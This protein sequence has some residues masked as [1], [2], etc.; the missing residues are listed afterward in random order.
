M[1][2]SYCEYCGKEYGPESCTKKY[3]K[4]TPKG[5]L[6]SALCS[7]D[8]LRTMTQI[9]P[10]IRV[11]A[12]ND[13]FTATQYKDMKRDTCS[14]CGAAVGGYHHSSCDNEI[15]PRCGCQFLSCD[16]GYNY[17]IELLDDW[18]DPELLPFDPDIV[19]S[20]DFDKPD[21]I[22]VSKGDASWNWVK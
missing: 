12:Y 22:L 11:G 1:S 2:V 21:V 19:S 9:L 18:K 3:I 14:D 6:K 10:R 17:D 5:E 13:F 16:C 8:H 7:E 20:E 4:Y 15:C